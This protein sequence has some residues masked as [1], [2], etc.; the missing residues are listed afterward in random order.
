MKKRYRAGDIA[1]FVLVL[2][3]IDVFFLF[4]MSDTGTTYAFLIQEN[5]GSSIRLNT[6]FTIL[7]TTS[8]AKNITYQATSIGRIE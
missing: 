3:P 5:S 8:S 1:I 6:F 7:H 2:L 4:Y